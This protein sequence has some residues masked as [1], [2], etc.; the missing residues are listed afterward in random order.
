M[1]WYN[2]NTLT[3]LSPKTIVVHALYINIHV[4]PFNRKMLSLKILAWFYIL[5]FHLWDFDTLN[6]KK[7]FIFVF[8]FVFF[9]I[10]NGGMFIL[11]KKNKTHHFIFL[12]Y[13]FMFIKKG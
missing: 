2:L 10:W 12:L 3:N 6:V 7:T 9:L 1:D 11:Y 4:H 8:I 13:S 5:N